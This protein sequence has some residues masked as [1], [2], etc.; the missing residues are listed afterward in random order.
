MHGAG[1][2]ICTHGKCVRGPSSSPAGHSHAGNKTIT[3]FS[4]LSF[5]YIYLIF[6]ITCKS[7][8]SFL[9]LQIR[10]TP[11]EKKHIYKSAICQTGIKTYMTYPSS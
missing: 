11:G 2:T 7:F 4:Y 10:R 1:T 6:A 3:W 9:F 8:T 5:I